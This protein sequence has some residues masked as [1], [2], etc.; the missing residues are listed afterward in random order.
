[1]LLSIW[2]VYNDIS[3]LSCDL[4]RRPCRE[5]KTD[6]PAARRLILTLQKLLE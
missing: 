5:T 1:M 2:F 6:H 4:C 3:I